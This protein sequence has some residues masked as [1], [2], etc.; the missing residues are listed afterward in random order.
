MQQP[1]AHVVQAA[2]VGP[3]FVQECFES[4][5]QQIFAKEGKVLDETLKL[6]TPRS[7]GIDGFARR[8]GHRYDT[9]LYDLDARRVIEISEGRKLE[10]VQKLLERLRDPEKVE[11]VSMDMSASFRPAVQLCLPKVYL[12]P[13][14]L[15]CM[16]L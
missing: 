2:Q 11:A 1:I 4:F 6:A 5:V 9:L 12:S 14:I 3:R 16:S 13:S 10:D 8:K 7:L 15:C